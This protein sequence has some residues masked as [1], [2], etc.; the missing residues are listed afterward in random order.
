MSA[1]IKPLTLAIAD[2]HV[3]FRKG[4]VALLKGM[5]GVEVLYEADNGRQLIDGMATRQPDLA[6][7]EM[8]EMNGVETT[9]QIRTRYPGV[10]ILIISMHDEED[11][12][13]NLLEEGAH[14]YLL[15]N[16]EPGEVRKALED[17]MDLGFYYNSMVVG[18]LHKAT[19]LKRQAGQQREALNRKEME[20]LLLLMQ[21]HTN[22]EIAEKLSLSIRT[23]ESRRA[24]IMEKTGT[25]NLA[26]LLRYA[27]DQGLV[28]KNGSKQPW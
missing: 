8:P 9:R 17:M 21:Q 22:A 28:D 24:R 1:P 15:K 2:D 14:G 10:K 12:I 3:L 23:V 7:V 18:V 26:G 25:R 19:L 16:A 4:L 6:I 27:I 13:L 11:L 5:K 20:V